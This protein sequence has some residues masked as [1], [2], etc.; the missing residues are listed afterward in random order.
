MLRRTKKDVESELCDK[1]ELFVPCPLTT[2]Q[3]FFHAALDRKIIVEDLLKIGNASASPPSPSSFSLGQDGRNLLSLVMQF[4][5]V[6]SNFTK[7]APFSIP[8]KTNFPMVLVLH[9][10][11]TIPTYLSDET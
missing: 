6:R 4:R 11:A 2:R 1:I 8:C 3:R 9:R 10:F 7:I 5:K